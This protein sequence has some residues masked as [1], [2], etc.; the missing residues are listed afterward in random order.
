MFSHVYIFCILGIQGRAGLRVLSARCLSAPSHSTESGGMQ[1]IQAVTNLINSCCKLT[2]E[3]NCRMKR[4][5]KATK[6][7]QMNK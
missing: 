5:Q 6:R 7:E 1:S 3:I 4:T 2:G